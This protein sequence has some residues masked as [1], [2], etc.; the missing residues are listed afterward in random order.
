[1]YCLQVIIAM[2]NRPTVTRD[3]FNREGS[4]IAS[5]GGFVLH[6][7]VFRSTAFIGPDLETHADAQEWHARPGPACWCW[8]DQIIGG[9]SRHEANAA[10][11]AVY[12]GFPVR[13]E[14]ANATGKGGPHL[15]SYR[16]EI[17]RKCGVEFDSALSLSHAFAKWH[18]L[19]KRNRK[20]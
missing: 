2:N 5:R 3:N 9:A 1:M 4:I 19:T 17:P 12:F 7:G 13:A 8:I 15:T 14:L 10:A 11:L 6:S 20:G 18:L 16:A